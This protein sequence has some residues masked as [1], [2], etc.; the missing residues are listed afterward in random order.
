[1]SKIETLTAY[2][3]AFSYLQRNNPLKEELKNKIKDGEL[4]DYTFSNF[5]DDYSKFTSDLAVGK[6]TERTIFCQKIK[7]VLEC[8]IMRPIDG[9]LNLMPVNKESPLKS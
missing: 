2:K 3:C 1:M 9:C 5:V 4:P 8:H 7:Y 6:S